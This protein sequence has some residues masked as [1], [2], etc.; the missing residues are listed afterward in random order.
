MVS[1]VNSP[2]APQTRPYNAYCQTLRAVIFTPYNGR[3]RAPNTRGHEM[4]DIWT[5]AMH[6]AAREH[7]WH[8]LGELAAA[9]AL[10]D[11]RPTPIEPEDPAETFRRTL[12]A[13]R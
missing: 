9:A 11:C 5:Q 4:R 8:T 10:D 7:D 2:D 12:E 6:N 1:D 13:R 3:G